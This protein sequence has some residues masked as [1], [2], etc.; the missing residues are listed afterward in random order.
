M[1]ARTAAPL[2]RTSQRSTSTRSAAQLCARAT[3][4]VS[5]VLALSTTSTRTESASPAPSRCA[6][7]FVA[8]AR[9]GSVSGVAV[10]VVLRDTLSVALV[11]G[12][13]THHRHHSEQEPDTA[14]DRRVHEIPPRYQPRL[15]TTYTRRPADAEIP[16]R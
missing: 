7:L 10:Q 13:S 16:A 5:S 12:D 1:P 3:A 14:S 2:P 11:G 9:S 15:C 6:R 8:G 4:A